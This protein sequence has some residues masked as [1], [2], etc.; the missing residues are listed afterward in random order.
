MKILFLSHTHA[1][2]AFRVGSHHLSGVMARLGNDV[3]HYSTPFSAFHRWA[4]KVGDDSGW[5]GLDRPRIDESG[6]TH[7]SPSVL[8]PAGIRARSIHRDLARRGLETEFDLV[9]IDQPLLWEPGLRNLGKLLV[10]RPTDLYPLGRKAVLQDKI[11]RFVDGVIGTSQPVT[12]QF[13]NVTIPKL[14]LENG[15]DSTFTS[16]YLS[17]N[18]RDIAIFVGAFDG[19]FDLEVVELLAGSNGN[20][21]FLLAGPGGPDKLSL[22]SN[23]RVLGAVNYFDLPLLMDEAKIGL[24]PL[25]SDP[26]NAGRSP[27]KLY[28]YLASGLNVVTTRTKVLR[29]DPDNGIFAY[30]G[31]QDAVVQFR[32]AAKADAPN[33][34]GRLLAEKYTWESKAEQLLEFVQELPIRTK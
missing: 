17:K 4:R 22:P 10:Y 15:V 26:L 24:L 19:R 33:E 14:T 27:M 8:V 16:K 3:V 31:K 1:F 6:V 5:A 30:Q 18:R 11:L 20:W 2:G 29:A 7:V 21:E 32:A 9:L 25:S 13:S 12:D 28:E 34:R 23:V